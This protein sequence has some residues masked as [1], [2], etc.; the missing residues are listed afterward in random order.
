[1]K[2]PLNPITLLRMIPTMAFQDIY[3]G[4]YSDILPN[5]LLQNDLTCL[6][7]PLES[8]CQATSARK[9]PD[10]MP[11]LMTVCLAYSM[12]LAYE[13]CDLAL[14]VE[15]QQ[16]HSDHIKYPWPEMQFPSD[17]NKKA[18]CYMPTLMT[19][20]PAYNIEV[21]QG[22]LWSWACCSGPAGTTAISRLQL[23]S[24]RTTLILGLLFGSGR[25]HCYLALAVEVRQGPLWSWACCSGPAGTTAISRLQ[26]GRDH[27]DPGLAVRVRQGPLRSRA[28][29]WGPAGITAIASLQLR[30]GG[31]REIGGGG[32]GQLT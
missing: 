27:F 30:Y 6:L 12:Y 20:Y 31:A 26:L 2:S 28:C 4:I 14:A 18:T 32:E 23:R 16:N 15:V 13:R 1:M 17:I 8:S 25:D 11:Y 19:F 21:R 24:G 9:Q 29:S 7:H 10:I 22:P 5:I 3:L